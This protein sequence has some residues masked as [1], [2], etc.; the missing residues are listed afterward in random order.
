[1]IN[2]LLVLL[3]HCMLTCM[4]ISSWTDLSFWRRLFLVKKWLCFLNW[5]FL[6]ILKVSKHWAVQSLSYLVKKSLFN[7][8]FFKSF[9]YVTQIYKIIKCLSVSIF[10]QIRA[11]VFNGRRGPN[12]RPNPRVLQW[13]FKNLKRRL[14]MEESMTPNVRTLP[15]LKMDK[16]M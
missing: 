4:F 14:D 1:M 15:H 3:L 8:F 11:Q 13:W 12:R 5:N 6:H 10:K 16:R 7:I 2:F 9:K